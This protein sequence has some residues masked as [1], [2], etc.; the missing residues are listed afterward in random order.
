[1]RLSFVLLAALPVLG[2]CEVE[3]IGLGSGMI[4]VRNADADDYS[5][6]ISDNDLCQLGLQSKIEN[7]TTTTFSVKSDDEAG[8]SFFCTS[9]GAGG[10]KVTSG[11]TYEIKGG[12]F[13]EVN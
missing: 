2:A 7:N 12:A 11:K 6:V 9:R 1:M 13:R 4:T 5:I 10:V 3:E 8:D